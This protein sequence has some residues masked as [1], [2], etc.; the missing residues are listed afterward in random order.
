MGGRTST[1][2]GSPWMVSI[3]GTCFLF[4]RVRIDLQ[5]KSRDSHSGTYW[6]WL[7]SGTGYPV[8]RL[9]SFDTKTATAN[10]WF[11][12]RCIGPE[13]ESFQFIFNNELRQR[14]RVYCKNSNRRPDNYSNV[15]TKQTSFIYLFSIA[16]H[17][18]LGQGLLTTEASR[19]YSRHTSLRTTPMVKGPARHRDLYLTTHNTHKRKAPMPPARFKPTIPASKRPQ[20]H[21]LDRAATRIG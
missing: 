8:R 10:I 16:Q 11:Q 7:R 21:T 9:P 17:P 14:L 12:A 3:R 2:R 15:I 1:A 19:S 18:L 20:R 5:N 13:I 6:F 4:L